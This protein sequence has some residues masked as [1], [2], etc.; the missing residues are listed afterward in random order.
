MDFVLIRNNYCNSRCKKCQKDIP[1]GKTVRWLKSVG[2]FCSDSC[3][4][5]YK[6]DGDKWHRLL[7]V[8]VEAPKSMQ[9]RVTQDKTDDDFRKLFDKAVHPRTPVE[10]ARTSA[11]IA[12]RM[13]VKRGVEV[14]PAGTAERIRRLDTV[15]EAARAIVEE[16]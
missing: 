7:N 14:H 6:T 10:E 15:L 1:I 5:R 4:V 8:L 9:A 16:P 11:F 3:A 12:L 13:L 2:I